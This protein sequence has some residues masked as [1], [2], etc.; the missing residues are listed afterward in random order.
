MDDFLGWL[1]PTSISASILAV[2]IFI[3]VALANLGGAIACE[4]QSVSFD[5]HE[6]TLLGGC[7][8]KHE[9]AW[10]PLDNIRGFD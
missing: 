3:I 7:M 2:V 9:G 10:L 1:I 5:G 6:Y 8:V 4:R